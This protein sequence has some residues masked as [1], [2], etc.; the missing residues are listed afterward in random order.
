MMMQ[1]VTTID[2]LLNEWGVWSQAGL[3]LTLSSASNDV[4][5]SIDD[6]MGLL[7][8]QAVAML[9]QYAPKTKM[10][11]MMSYRSKLSTRQIAKNLDI[12]ETKARQLLLSGSAWLEG[13]LMAKGVLIKTAA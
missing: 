9:G 5:T 13:H 2:D 12:G 3:G 10:V 8:D 1:L 4:I 11:V 6:D 7:I